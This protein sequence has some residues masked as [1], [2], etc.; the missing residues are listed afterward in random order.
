MTLVVAVL[1]AAGCSAREDLPDVIARD[2]L[3][4]DLVGLDPDAAREAICGAGLVVG[5]VDVVDGARPGV[6]RADGG[7]VAEVLV[8]EPPG[9]ARV[10]AGEAIRLGLAVSRNAS[11][12]MRTAC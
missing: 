9:G 6:L 10:P 8:T 3:V 12:V 1:V 2:V 4:P 11:V 7:T 5:A